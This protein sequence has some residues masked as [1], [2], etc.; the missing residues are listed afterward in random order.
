MNLNTIKNALKEDKLDDLTGLWRNHLQEIFNTPDFKKYWRE[1]TDYNY[2]DI[3][4]LV[5]NKS[6]DKRD[7]I[8]WC[9][10]GGAVSN[11]MLSYLTGKEPVLNDIDIFVWLKGNNSST[12][13]YY[14]T[15]KVKFVGVE[16]IGKF[17]IIYKEDKDLDGFLCTDVPKPV[18]DEKY[19]RLVQEFDYNAC[20]AYFHPYSEKESFV[21][22]APFTQFI[23]EQKLKIYNFH[24]PLSTV[25]RGVKKQK[26]L[27][28]KF[29]KSKVVEILAN[30]FSEIE[31]EKTHLGEKKKAELH[32]CPEI[33]S[34]WFILDKDKGVYRSIVN[35]DA[36]I[37]YTDKK[38]HEIFSFFRLPKNQR[39]RLLTLIK[40]DFFSFSKIYQL[41][42][43]TKVSIP[44]FNLDQ[45]KRL[46]PFMKEHGHNIH[47]NPLHMKEWL[48]L[49]KKIK[50]YNNIEFIGFCENI[51]ARDY[52]EQEGEYYKNIICYDFK[53]LKSQYEK[54][55]ENEKNEILI[56]PLELPD[57]FKGPITELT[58]TRELKLEGLELSHCVG[59]YST[60]VREGRSRIFKIRYNNEKAT[61]EL[62][63]N[64]NAKTPY[65]E[66]NQL[67]GFK[68]SA[69]S[70][71]TTSFVEKLVNFFNQS[72]KKNNS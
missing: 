8:F 62:N 32:E 24:H 2:K 51:F 38:Y 55:L 6:P 12:S 50:K 53:D 36:L 13:R 28:V 46:Q 31:I 71:K 42:N 15:E 70:V 40:H 3:N 61:L 52:N 48:T 66:V 54:Q 60:V 56:S 22:L 68:N 23:K 7:V 10:A 34:P 37:N 14:K 69:V 17:N 35:K 63:L 19:R 30:L 44:D 65:Y 1:K 39:D 57:D 72:L 41:V 26:E 45:L 20:M 67:K 43:A 9:I 49:I 58:T 18:R 59:G 21:A 4:E 33:L 11:S 47:I 29:D 64:T 16:R 27:N 25:I 5:V